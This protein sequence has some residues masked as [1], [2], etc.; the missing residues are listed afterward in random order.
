MTQA[1]CSQSGA[2]SCQVE[3]RRCLSQLSVTG[4]SEIRTAVY[5][6]C[7]F[8]KGTYEQV[9][10]NAAEYNTLNKSAEWL[11]KTFIAGWQPIAAGHG[12]EPKQ[13]ECLGWKVHPLI[14]GKFEVANL[15]LFSMRVYQSL[16]GQLHRQLQQHPPQGK[17]PWFKFW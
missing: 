7:R 2:G 16:M 14:G 1:R 17:K 5:G 15:Q 11:D 12:L 13:D 6:C 9:A 4:S 10:R 8:L 3:T